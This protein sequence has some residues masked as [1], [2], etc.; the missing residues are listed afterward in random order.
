MSKGTLKQIS[1]GSIPGLEHCPPLFHFDLSEEEF[2][3]FVSNPEPTLKKLGHAWNGGTITLARWG[4]SFSEKKGWA[5]IS[6][7]DP[8]Q[9]PKTP[10]GCCYVTDGGMICHRHD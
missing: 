9:R 4:E 7:A 10:R 6:Q 5:R 8:S 1:G 2:L 3:Q